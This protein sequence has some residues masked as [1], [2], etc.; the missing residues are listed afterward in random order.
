[1]ARAVYVDSS[2]YLC[3]LLLEDGHR[4]LVDEIATGEPVSSVLLILEVKRNLVRLSRQGVLPSE[5]LSVTFDRLAA[6]RE[7][8][9]LRALTHDLCDDPRYPV[10]TTPRSL[11]LVHLRT[12]LWFHERDPLRR[13]LTRDD[14]QR[15]GAR[16]LGLPV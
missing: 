10:V 7:L 9:R 14:A 16:E 3:V 13:F 1:M 15:R 5:R 8:F 6:D 11:D 4:E 2:A 12:A